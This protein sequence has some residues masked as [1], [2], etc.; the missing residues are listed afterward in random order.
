V[1]I[2][3]GQVLRAQCRR[4]TKVFCQDVENSMLL[5]YSGKIHLAYASYISISTSSYL[6]VVKTSTDPS[7]QFIAPFKAGNSRQA[8][9]CYTSQHGD[10]KKVTCYNWFHTSSGETIVLMTLTH[11]ALK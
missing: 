4:A 5:Y 8:Q 1:R 11:R 3:H 10:T 9:S 2:L 7:Q 6:Q